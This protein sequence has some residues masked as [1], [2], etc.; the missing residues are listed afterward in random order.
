MKKLILLAFIVSCFSSFSQITVDAAVDAVGAMETLLGENVTVSNVTW[1]GAASQIGVFDCVDC[2]LDF[3]SGVIMSSGDVAL[4]VGPNNQGAAGISLLTGAVNDADMTLAEPTNLQFFDLAI[5]EFDFVALGDSVWFDYIWASDE[6]PNFI[7]GGEGGGINDQFAF[8]MSGPGI[9][10]IFSDGAENLAVIPGTD[11]AVTNFNINNGNTGTNGPCANCEYY[12]HNGTGAPGEPQFTDETVVQYD[13]Y[14]TGLRAIKG[15]LICGETYHLKIAIADVGDGIYDSAVILKAGSL[16]SNLTVQV[17]LVIEATN[18]DGVMNEECGISTL[19]FTRPEAIAADLPFT[20][21]IEYSGDA[22]N[23]V[24]YTLLPETVSF[25]PGETEISFTVDA[26]EDG[27]IEG[28]ESVILDMQS[29]AVCE[30]ESVPSTFEFFITESQPLDVSGYDIEIC[31]GDSIELAPIINGGSG[32]FLYDW[33]TTE[34]T[35]SIIVQPAVSSTYSVNISDTCIADA[36]MGEFIVNVASFPAMGLTSNPATIEIGCNWFGE[37]L[38]LSGSGGDGNYS[39]AWYQDGAE[40]PSFFGPTLSLWNSAITELVGEV[41]DGCGTQFSIDIPVN[42]NVPE[43]E[44]DIP[45]EVFIC[46]GDYTIDATILGGT[47]PYNFSWYDQAFNFTFEEDYSGNTTVDEVINFSVSDGCGLFFNQLVN[48]TIVAPIPLII[49]AGEDTEGACLEDVILSGTVTSGVEPYEHSWMTLDNTPVG[50]NDQTTFTVSQDETIIYT[51]A[52]NCG[53]EETD[54][55]EITLVQV[56]LEIS[57]PEFLTGDCTEEFQIEAEP[58]LENVN[59]TYSWSGSPEIEVMADNVVTYQSLESA[60]IEV[61][62]DAGC[63][64]ETTENTEIIVVSPPITSS[65]V[66]DTTICLGGI[67]ALSVTADGG[68]GEL[69]Y[70]WSALG[71]T[72][73]FVSVDPSTD[74]TYFVTITDEC[75]NQIIQSV[76][77]NV[78]NISVSYTTESDDLYSALFTPVIVPECLDCSYNWSFSDGN[79]SDEEMPYHTFTESGYIGAFL[80]VTTP[81]G[82]I[83]EFTGLVNVP[84]IVYIPNSFTP[85]NDGV[86]DAFKVEIAGIDDYQLTI[87]NRWGEMVFSSN[88]PSEAWTGD[89][90]KGSHY[91][92]EGVYSYVLEYR[93]LDSQAEVRKGTVTVI[94]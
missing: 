69:A 35:P 7:N 3:N 57:M 54:T 41:T 30:G 82:C 78:D 20:V 12:V 72:D 27:V 17:E 23:G 18:E 79:N 48:V 10:G 71:S 70:L 90:N 39:Y 64:N 58:N 73:S 11:L 77:V 38:T 36:G 24:D 16:S 43:L 4:A 62:A 66:P 32:G 21:N 37:T 65:I 25:L 33:S 26:F 34:E 61:T 14:T 15:G 29:V 28:L 31:D 59:I 83:A 80:E 91:V 94:R 19:T 88:D 93:S 92:P 5:L 45:E 85:D 42:F 81:A 75:T 49:D 9:D 84:P 86:N 47:A 44:V 6:Y 8:F 53:Q 13:G 55:L 87:F 68:S 52:D 2:G 40:E 67:A 22:E 46:P 56:P 74:S 76:E 63:G 1:S 50:N 51:V 60:T 89:F